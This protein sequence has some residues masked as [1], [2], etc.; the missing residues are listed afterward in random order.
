MVKDEGLTWQDPPEP[1]KK[2][3]YAALA[4]R[5]KER[6]SQWA[7]LDQPRGTSARALVAAINR[8]S[9]KALQDRYEAVGRTIDGE[10]RIFVRFNP[11]LWERVIDHE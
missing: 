11:D 1:E 8:G 5:L 9:S 2:G 3:K 7:L 4:K 6:P 10:I